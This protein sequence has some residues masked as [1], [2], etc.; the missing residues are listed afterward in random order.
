MLQNKS[1]QHLFNFLNASVS[2]FHTVSHAQDQLE[3]AGFQALDFK[4]PWVLVPGNAYYCRTFSGELFAFKLGKELK[5]RNGIRIAGGH[6]D[7]PCMKLKPAPAFTQKGYLQANVEVYGGPILNTFF[8]RPLS[9]AGKIS[10]R[11]NDLLHPQIRY[12][13]LKKPVCII[14][15]LAIHMNRKVNEGVAIDQQAHLMPI[16]GMVEEKLNQGDMLLDYIASHE[17][18]DPK[19]L[20]DYELYLYNLDAPA[21]IGLNDELISSPRL[22]DT[23]AVSAIIHG[24]IESTPSDTL[25]L[26]ALFDN[27]EIGSRT[28]QG[29]D[30]WTLN[31]VLEKIWAAFGKSSVECYSHIS[32]SMILSIDVGHGYHPNYPAT[33]DITTFPVLGKGFVIK[34]DS[35]Q[36][37]A[38]DCEA[39][40]AMLQL[41]QHYN[42]PCQRFAKRSGM[43]GGGTIAS[44]VSSHIPLKTVDMGVPLLSMHSSREL[45]AASDQEAL[46]NAVKAFMSL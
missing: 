5:L 9:I 3:A 23:T 1:V 25:C 43:A 42:I 31:L 46:E 19:D 21:A 15:N 28:K 12:I 38:W 34:S 16:L 24:L 14:P 39:I 41:C 26:G 37:Y 11:S 13:D 36:K 33:G 29:A 45:M 7:W 30:A 35:N 27:E 18:I 8:D 17:N 20:L 22:D 6:T 44:L 2:P 4:E 10:V 40:G 32:D